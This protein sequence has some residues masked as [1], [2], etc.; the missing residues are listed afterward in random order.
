[1]Y[2]G[3]WYINK[4]YKIGDIIYIS[5]SKD[6]YICS[7]PHLSDEFHF[8]SQKNAF[9]IK[10]DQTFITHIFQN[11]LKN[12]LLFNFEIENMKNM[13]KESL[14]ANNDNEEDEDY[15]ETNSDEDT[16]SDDKEENNKNKDNLETEDIKKDKDEFEIEINLLKEDEYMDSYEVP[17]LFIDNDKIIAKRKLRKMEKELS[18]FKKQKYGDTKSLSLRDRLVLLDID[19]KT[20][21]FL[22]EKHENGM[23]MTGSDYSKTMNWLETVCN[24]PH[25][26][27]K[28]M[29]VDMSND[30]EEIKQFFEDVKSNLDKHIYGLE[31]VKEEILEFIARKIRNNDGKGHVLALCGPA[32]VGKSKILKCLAES[33]ELP[34]FQINC[35]GL[36][37][38]NI[39]IGHSET[40]TNSKSGKIVDLLQKSE[41]M[42]PIIYFDEIDK[43]SEHKSREINGILTHLLDEEQNDKFQDNYLA[44]VNINLSK[45]LFVISFNEI[46]NVD[47][48][49]SDRMKIIHINPPNLYEKIIICKNKLLPEIIK[50][51][52]FSKNI[53]INI[54][55]DILKSI[56][57]KNCNDEQGVRTCKKIIEKI[58]NKLNY[59]ILV[60]K[61]IPCHII[62]KS[63]E[64]EGEINETTEYII[65]EE[66]IDIIQKSLTNNN[67][68]EK[69]F[70]MYN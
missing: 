17:E 35:G 5:I 12:D 69:Y 24:I 18:K 64:I 33:L 47:S 34:F 65:T 13:I 56:I 1:M 43:I 7:M 26:K 21:L 6:Y 20:K 48:I 11:N 59:D 4:L 42:N 9:W 55:E 51:I 32:G 39:L 44:N 62:K 38:A 31:D 2:L 3:N 53:K 30:K 70:H 28:P 15:S 29:R 60:E 63:E 37:D 8:P 22:I 10:I 50:T 52:G 68:D 19:L 40:Y 14:N 36:N 61:D 58:L 23:K 57:L 67:K 25:N 66:Y 45:A 46:E 27:F 49:V 16:S 41:Y 54:D